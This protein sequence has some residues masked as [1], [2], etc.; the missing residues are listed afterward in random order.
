MYEN[1]LA[2]YNRWPDEMDEH[3][4]LRQM[5]VLLE[6]Q[7]KRQERQGKLNAAYI[8]STIFG[9]EKSNGS[10]SSDGPNVQ[11]TKNQRSMSHFGI[12]V[13]EGGEE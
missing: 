11:R 4:S 6:T 7:M 5:G 8:W 1:F 3:F 9:D 2:V 12:A 10:P 13:T